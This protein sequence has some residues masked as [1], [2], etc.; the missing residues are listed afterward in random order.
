MKIFIGQ[1]LVTTVVTELTLLYPVEI[2]NETKSVFLLGIVSMLFNATNA[3]GS[4]VWGSV[5]D[6]VR[7]RKEFFILLPLS[8]IPC[9]FLLSSGSIVLGFLG[10]SL[11]GFIYAIDSPLYSILLLENFTFEQLPK[12]NIRLSQFTLA[13]NITGSLLAIVRLPPTC[14][15][16]MLVASLVSNAMFLRRVAGSS[17][18]DKKEEKREIRNRFQAILSFFTFNFAAEIFYTVYVPFNYAMGNPE[19]LIFVSYTLL[20]ILDEFLYYVSSRVIENREVFFIYL[21]T[22]TRAILSLSASLVVASKIRLGPLSVPIFLSFGSIYP[23]FSSSFFSIMFRNLK[24]NRGTII[25]VFNAVEDVANIMGS[26]VAGIIGGT[27]ANAY[28]VVLYS[29]LLSSFLFA[30]YVRRAPVPSS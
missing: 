14:I 24:K 27:L 6:S 22:F 16:S 19:Y 30:D 4:Y 1:A 26:L 28:A 3:L 9:V 2:Y 17:N 13:G 5:I 15:I 18:R 25:G 11:L 10:Y 21:V 8:I 23:I 20:Y 12:V 29:F 7:R